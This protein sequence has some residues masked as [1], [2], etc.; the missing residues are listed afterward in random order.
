MNHQEFLTTVI[1]DGIE[2]ARFSY[3]QPHNTIKLKGSLQGFEECRGKEV[4]ELAKLLK[5]AEKTTQEAM[6][7]QSPDYWFWRCRHLEIE[8]V[9]NVV[10]AVLYNENQPV[11]IQPSARGMVKAAE[12]LGVAPKI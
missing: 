11:I 9:C 4:E 5:E 10:S 8:W 1:E 7:A 12:I 6:M 3:K 2:G